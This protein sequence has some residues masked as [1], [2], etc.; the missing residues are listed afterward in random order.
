[1]SSS[2]P[3]VVTEQPVPC[4]AGL[5]APAVQQHMAWS[6]PD[7]RIM[8]TVVP[9]M[10]TYQLVLTVGTRVVAVR[11]FI[12]AVE[13]GSESERLRTAYLDPSRYYQ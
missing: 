4:F 6:S 10:S 12:D 2:H 13:A 8:C 7:K 3:G 5:A 1:M 11:A 9:Y